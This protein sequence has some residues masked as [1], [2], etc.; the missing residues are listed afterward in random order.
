MYGCK[1][2]NSIDKL[3]YRM[4]CQNA[5]KIACDHLPPCSDALDLHLMGANYQAKIWRKRERE[6]AAVTE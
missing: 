4:Y 5:G 6:L 1:G 3:R 2:N